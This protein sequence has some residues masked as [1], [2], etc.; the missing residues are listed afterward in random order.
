MGV[1]VVRVSL[2]GLGFEVRGF[3]SWVVLGCVVL[4]LLN[5]FGYLL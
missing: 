3:G 2:V 4:V 1:F 5:D